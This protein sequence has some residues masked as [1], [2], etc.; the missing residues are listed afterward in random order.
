MRELDILRVSALLH[1]I[2]KIECWA[3]GK[4][5]SEHIYYTYRFLKDLLGEEIAE[6]SMRHHIG[7]S[8][9]TDIFPR[10]MME[11]I[12]CFADN[13]ASGADRREEPIGV[14]SKTKI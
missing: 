14:S 6:T 13:L 10:L 5:W 2:G 7:R 12:I 4:P 3:Y 8:Y 1:D 11:K 9:P